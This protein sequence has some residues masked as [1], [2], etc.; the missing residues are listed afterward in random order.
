MIVNHGAPVALYMMF[1]NFGRKHA[2][3]GTTQA[4]KAGLRDHIWT[5][6]EIIALL[7]AHE[8]NSTRAARKAS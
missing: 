6:E 5:I 3:L 4:V 1:Y 7:E 8:P 2:T